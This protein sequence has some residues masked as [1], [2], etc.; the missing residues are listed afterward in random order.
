MLRST[1]S[2][3]H[4]HIF[5]RA[6]LQVTLVAWNVVNVSQHDWVMAF[7]SGSAVSYV[8]WTNSKSAALAKAEYGQLCYALGAGC[9]TIIGMAT[10]YLL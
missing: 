2:N 4:T 10:G 5:G 9:G 8:W 3:E 7:L 1:L 6:L